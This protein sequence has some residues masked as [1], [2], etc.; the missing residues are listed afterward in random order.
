MF[1]TRL[2]EVRIKNG[3]TQQ[4]AADALNLSL[5]SYQRYEANNGKCDPPLATLVQIANL[6]N[7]SIDYLLGRDEYL[8][9]LGVSVDEFL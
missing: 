8:Q 1:S 9:S 3:F 6:F 5:R 7:T 2:K 4:S